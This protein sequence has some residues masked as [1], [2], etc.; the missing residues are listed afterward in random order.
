VRSH[1]EPSE[2]RSYSSTLPP[3]PSYPTSYDGYSATT[4]RLRE[5]SALPPSISLRNRRE[6]SQE[7]LMIR[8]PTS[9]TL[10]KLRRSSFV[11]AGGSGSSKY[12]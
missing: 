6:S 10:I 8:P 12:Y 11:D 1:F 7:R 9:S 5:K 4:S 3:R 2:S